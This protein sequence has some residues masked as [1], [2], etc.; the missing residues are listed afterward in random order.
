MKSGGGELSQPGTKMGSMK[1]DQAPDYS[2]SGKPMRWAET[3]MASET[4]RASGAIFVA[5]EVSCHLS[6]VC[7]CLTHWIVTLLLACI[8]AS[9]YSEK[10]QLLNV[11][12]QKK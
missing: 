7:A 2:S 3:K 11:K 12:R 5:E 4:E 1:K 9:F 8:S 6:F 10:R